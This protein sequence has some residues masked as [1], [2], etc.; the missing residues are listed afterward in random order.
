[1][2]FNVQITDIKNKMRN[3][4]CVPHS[5]HIDISGYRFHAHLAF[6]VA[7]LYAECVS[8]EFPKIITHSDNDRQLRMHARKVTRN[9]CVKRS[10]NCKLAAAFLREITKCQKFNLNNI[11][12]IF[13]FFYA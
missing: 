8:A 3:S 11:T 10:D 1:V 6:Q 4:R 7:R 12:L 2:I 9:Y 5:F 13:Y